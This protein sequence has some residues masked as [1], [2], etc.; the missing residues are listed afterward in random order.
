MDEILL[1]VPFY[2]FLQTDGASAC[3]IMS[4]DKALEMGFKP[5]A[6]LRYYEIKLKKC[7]Y[8]IQFLSFTAY[9]LF[10]LCFSIGILYMSHR[11][12]K[13]SFYWGNFYIS[14]YTELE[15]RILSFWTLWILY[16]HMEVSPFCNNFQTSLLHT[17][18]SGESWTQVAGHWCFWIPRSI[19]SEFAF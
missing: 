2:L 10:F 14:N 16:G 3:L 17:Q 7:C 8:S 15:F 6:Y 9:V 4:E 19:C 5:K 18:S 12:P 11:I 1:H 13:I